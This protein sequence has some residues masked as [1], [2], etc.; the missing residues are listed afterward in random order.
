LSVIPTVNLVSNVGS[1][2]AATHCA[3]SPHLH[4]PAVPMAFPLRHPANVLTDFQADDYSQRVVFGAVKPRGR[5]AWMRLFP[6]ASP[7]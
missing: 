6:G 1:G 2:E 4:R 7:H 3:D 5:R